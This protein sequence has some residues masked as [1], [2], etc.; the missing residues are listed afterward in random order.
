MPYDDMDHQMGNTVFGTFKYCARGGPTY[1]SY[2]CTI[3]ANS[4]SLSDKY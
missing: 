4:T 2:V 1:V 3:R